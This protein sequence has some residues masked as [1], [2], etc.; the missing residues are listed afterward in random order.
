MGIMVIEGEGGGR[1]GG[2]DLSGLVMSLGLFDVL[3]TLCILV[4]FDSFLPPGA[5]FFF[6][7]F[8]YKCVVFEY[9]S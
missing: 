8:F 3:V 2:G 6:F 1:G 9:S 4:R 5:F 7:F